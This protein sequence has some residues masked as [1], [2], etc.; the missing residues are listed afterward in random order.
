M[1]QGKLPSEVVA[2][3]QQYLN[4]MKR[5]VEEQEKKLNETL[6]QLGLSEEDLLKITTKQVCPY[7][8]DHIVPESAFKKHVEKCKLLNAGYQKDEL[9]PQL[10]NSDFWYS[11]SDHILK[12]DID[13]NKLN[14]IIWDH[15]VQTGQ[16]Y[17]GHRSMPASDMDNSILLTQEDRLAVYRHVVQMSH[18]AGKVIPIDRTD[19]LLTTDWGSLIKKGLLNDESNKEFSSKL[20]QLAALRDLKRRRQSYRAKNVHITKKSY[21]EIIREVII[22]QMEVLKPAVVDVKPTESR[23]NEPKDTDR[24]ERSS[25]DERRDPQDSRDHDRNKRRDSRERNR[26][27]DNRHIERRGD[28]RDRHRERQKD[29]RVKD[30]RDNSRDRDR[31]KDRSPGS[32][33]RRQSPKF[34]KSRDQSAANSRRGSPDRYTDKSLSKEPYLTNVALTLK[35]EDFGDG[36]EREGKLFMSYE[37]EGL[38]IKQEVVSDDSDKTD[39]RHT[40]RSGVGHERKNRKRKK[41]SHSSSS[42][43]SG[44]GSDDQ[45]SPDKVSKHK[46][47]KHKKKH[48]KKHKRKSR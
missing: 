14:K 11:S 13:E 37:T 27:S 39:K 15:C 26:R 22:N 30:R 45:N 7:N 36:R 24:F 35:E 41:R 3:R 5:F 17:T 20:E 46:K 10:E 44:S 47:S 43:H 42:D 21:K 29:R 16:V 18:E 32:E 40:S 34:S 6:N 9:V 48:S 25:R 8:K 28:S 1:L 2:K 19:E 23:L 12:V 38:Q 31:R 4:S 33:S